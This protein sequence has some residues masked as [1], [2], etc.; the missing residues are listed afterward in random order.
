MARHAKDFEIDGLLSMMFEA[1]AR[2]IHHQIAAQDAA[3]EA[4]LHA[5][6]V[7]RVRVVIK[8]AD[9]W[10]GHT[11]LFTHMAEAA[12]DTFVAFYHEKQ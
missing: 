4:Q 2:M 1:F 7:E 12:V 6:L 10:D 9:D 5:E 3:S 8:N 11:D